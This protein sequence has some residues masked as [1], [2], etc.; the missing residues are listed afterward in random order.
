MVLS[1][2]LPLFFQKTMSRPVSEEMVRCYHDICIYLNVVAPQ[3]A[4]ACWEIL[5]GG[6]LVTEGMMIGLIVMS[7]R[8]GEVL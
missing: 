6:S 5:R 4:N 3:T 1:Q 7:P 8:P 2:H